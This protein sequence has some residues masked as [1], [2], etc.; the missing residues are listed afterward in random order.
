[1]AD[2]AAAMGQLVAA[3]TALLVDACTVTRPGKPGQTPVLDSNGDPVVPAPTQV[4]AGPCALGDARIQRG[5]RMSLHPNLNDLDTAL[6]MRG[7]KVPLTADL[8][9]GDVVTITAA[10]FAPNLAGDRFEVLREDERTYS[11]YRSYQLKGASYRP[12]TP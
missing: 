6:S 1:M 10:A 8:Q 2:L 11:T 4:Y 12:P 9:P 3:R 7:L 5:M